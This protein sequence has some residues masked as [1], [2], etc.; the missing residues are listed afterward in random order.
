V[1]IVDANVLLYA[2][3]SDSDFHE[4]SRAWLDRALSGQDRVGFSWIAL[5]AFVRLSTK[6][7]LMPSPLPVRDAMDQVVAWLGAPSAAIAQPT[8]RHG[9]LLTSLLVE[10]GTGGNLTNDAHLAALAIEHRGTV[11]SY[12]TDFARFSG[13]S[14]ARPEDLLSR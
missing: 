11:V 14:W 7:G 13:V 12:D 8:G 5:L 10:A 3:N 2:V 1:R 4:D 6:V 9:D